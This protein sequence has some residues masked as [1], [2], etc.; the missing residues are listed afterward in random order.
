MDQL[1]AILN[2]CEIKYRDISN[3]IQQLKTTI[4]EQAKIKNGN[5]VPQKYLPQT[6]HSTQQDLTQTFL[7]Q[8][9]HMFQVHLERVIYANKKQLLKMKNEL[10]SILV[11]TD[12]QLMSLD[13]PNATLSSF[14]EKFLRDIEVSDHVPLPE[15]NAKLTKSEF[16]NKSPSWKRKQ[17]RKCSQPHSIKVPKIDQSRK[18]RLVS[19]QC[20]STHNCT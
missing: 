7:S 15:L 18:K 2:E 19:F 11:Q 16:Q 5:E 1:R 8:Y 9:K 13:V 17:R 20:T 6:L 12:R 10:E 3:K 14:Y 4:N